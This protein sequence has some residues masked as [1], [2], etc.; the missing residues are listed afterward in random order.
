MRQVILS[1]VLTAALGVGL[2]GCGAPKAEIARVQEGVIA[3][4]AGDRDRLIEVI[5][6]P[7]AAEPERDPCSRRA[8]ADDHR[9]AADA[10]LQ[11]LNSDTLFSLSEEA[12]LAYLSDHARPVAATAYVASGCSAASSRDRGARR[13]LVRAYADEVLRWRRDLVIQY[14]QPQMDQ[15]MAVAFHTLET[16]HLAGSPWRRVAWGRRGG[17]ASY[18]GD[19]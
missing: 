17:W 6:E 11:G 10:L 5:G 7:R 2:A 8:I 14:G 4:R 16:N 13:A 3:Y 1:T 12:R 15:R 18:G 19:L 9:A